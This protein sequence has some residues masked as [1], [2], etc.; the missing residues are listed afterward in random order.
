MWSGPI[1]AQPTNT[2]QWMPSF[3]SGVTSRSWCYNYFTFGIFLLNDQTE[4]REDECCGK[5]ERIILS[6]LQEWMEGRELPVM[7]ESLV[8]TLKDIKLP[9]PA[10][11]I[12]AAKYLLLFLIEVY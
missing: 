7:W 2:A 12:E 10:V 6:I 9:N 3:K 1:H 8:Q 5:S 4:S 11:Q